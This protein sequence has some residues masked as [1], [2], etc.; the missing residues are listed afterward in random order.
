MVTPTVVPCDSSV[1]IA[2]LIKDYSTTAEHLEKLGAKVVTMGDSLFHGWPGAAERMTSR[3][4][5]HLGRFCKR[6]AQALDHA[7]S[8][9]EIYRKAVADYETAKTT[10]DM[11]ELNTKAAAAAKALVTASELIGKGKKASIDAAIERQLPFQ[12]SVPL[13]PGPGAKEP[14]LAATIGPKSK[15]ADIRRAQEVLRARGWRVTVNGKW[16]TQTAG[17]VR[18]FQSNKHVAHTGVVDK[19]TWHAMWTKKII[20]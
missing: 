13:V 19:A 16:D 11:T 7:A 4:L 15:P 2:S 6:L 18:Q 8:A 20:W 10:P 12:R 5:R 3:E 17:V 1:E 9:L 14:L